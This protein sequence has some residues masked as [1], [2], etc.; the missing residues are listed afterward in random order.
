MTLGLGSGLGRYVN[1]Q[2]C[3]FE[4]GFWHQLW[5]RISVTVNMPRNWVSGYGYSHSKST[6]VSLICIEDI[7]T[8]GPWATPGEG[9]LVVQ[10]DFLVGDGHPMLVISLNNQ[11]EFLPHVI[12]LLLGV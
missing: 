3:G 2:L 4:F 11:I 5:V 1:P 12:K 8:T 10:L 6:W 7:H 9:C